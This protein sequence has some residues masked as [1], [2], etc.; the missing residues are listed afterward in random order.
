M[1]PLRHIGRGDFTATIFRRTHPEITKQGGLWPESAKMYGQMADPHV[2]EKKWVFPGGSQVQFGTCQYEE[3]LLKWHGS[4]IC[5]LGFDELATFTEHQ[6]TYLLS[7]NRSTC[8]VRPYVR[9]TTNPD[10]GSWVRRWVNWWVG[11]DGYP[12]QE[13]SGVLRWFRREGD[14]MLWSSSP[15]GPWE[16]DDGDPREPTEDVTPKSFTFIPASLSDNKALMASD[17]GYLANLQAL[18]RVEKERLLKGNWNIVAADGEWPADYFVG[19]DLWYDAPPLGSDVV[20]VSMGVDPSAT[21]TKVGDYRAIVVMSLTRDGTLWVDCD[22]D[23]VSADQVSKDVC[24]WAERY[25]DRLDIIVL[26]VNQFQQLFHVDIGREASARNM[27]LP[28]WPVNNTV[29]KEVRIRRLGPFL[30]Q[31][32]IRFRAGPMGRLLVQ[33]LSAFPNGDHDDGPDGAEMALRG[34]CRMTG[35]DEST[36]LGRV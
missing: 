11:D 13:R 32:R 24:D 22:L 7:R 25:R 12:I 5:M 8:G 1:E 28:V 31:R 30:Q 27:T 14:V 33:Q 19:A 35:V 34:L 16:N 4:Q 6:F 36:E 23:R 10:A 2:Q 9:A 3:D 20:A 15:D 18:P 21:Q 26:E 17:P 29:R